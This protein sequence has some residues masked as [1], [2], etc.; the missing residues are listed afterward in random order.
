[1]RLAAIVAIGLT[2]ACARR[3]PVEGM[4]IGVQPEKRT[5]VV[6]HRAIP[7]YMPAMTMPFTARSEREL[8]GLHPGS[9]VQFRL[10]VKREVAQARDFRIQPTALEGIAEDGA[11]FR[12]APPKEKLA[13]GDAVP[14]FVLT[15]HTGRSTRLAGF[16]GRVV[17]VQ[18]LYTRCPLPEVCPRLAAGFASIRHRYRDRL[19]RDLVLL[20]IT[21]DPLHDTVAV[22]S[23]YAATLR[24]DPESWRFLTGSKEGV[25]AVARRFGMVYWA[26]EGQIV[27]TAATAVIDRSGRLAA[28]V[29]GASFPIE[30]LS[31]LVR[32]VLEKSE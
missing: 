5:V 27:H 13:P 10:H 19:G 8:A 1:M 14:D 16:A 31:A 9:R 25:E 2:A 28:M 15:D 17:V 30:Q 4:V 26:E 29:E 20:S 32:S 22:L 23:R 18:F 7:G 3:Y 24:A 21:L 12:V 11:V 6:A